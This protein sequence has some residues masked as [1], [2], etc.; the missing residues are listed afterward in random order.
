MN[1]EQHSREICGQY[2]QQNML[3]IR[4]TVLAQYLN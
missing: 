2:D 4:Y 3:K 1:N